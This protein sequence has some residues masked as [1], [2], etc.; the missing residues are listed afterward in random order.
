M[1]KAQSVKHDTLQL[2]H[3]FMEFKKTSNPKV[4]DFTKIHQG[5]EEWCTLNG[6]Q[7]KPA[8]RPMKEV[9]AHFFDLLK[10]ALERDKVTIS[11][12]FGK[13]F[14]PGYV[15]GKKFPDLPPDDQERIIE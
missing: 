15:L 13:A 14:I 6:K 3:F 9:L 5:F 10:T 8:R 4:A 7:K 1:F 2:K 12:F 11:K